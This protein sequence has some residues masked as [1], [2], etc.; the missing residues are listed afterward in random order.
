[1]AK[2][3]LAQQSITMYGMIDEFTQYVNTGKGYVC[4]VALVER[5]IREPPKI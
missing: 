1:M 3:V 4:Q 5:T 2:G